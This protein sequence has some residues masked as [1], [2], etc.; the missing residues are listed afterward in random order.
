MDSISTFLTDYSHFISLVNGLAFFVLGLSVA[1]ESE[2]LSSPKLAGPLRM[3]SGYGFMAAL[4]NWLRMFMLTQSQPAPSSNALFLQVA[5]LLSLLLAGTFL[6]GF[7]TQ[8]IA[9]THRRYRWVR[10]GLP[11]VCVLYAVAVASISVAPDALRGEWVSA[12]DVYARYLLLLPGLALATLGLWSQHRD[13]LMMG[14]PR[15]AGASLGASLSFGVK[16]IA[17][18]VVAFPVHG[19]SQSLPPAAVLAISASRTLASIA[20]AFFVVR[21]LR[22]LEIERNRQLNVAL[23]QRV[24]AQQEA[25]AAQRQVHSEVERWARQ[26]E[27]LVDGVASAMSKATSLEEILDVS[28]GQVL[29]LTGFDAGEILLAQEGESELQLI[30]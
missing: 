9:G 7:A 28:L 25:L 22:A 30:T 11:V 23:E 4:A 24:Q 12:A 19:F 3:L 27:D 13:S 20:I 15:I 5:R 14:L 6:L 17:S 18:G 29:Q 10:W 1:L 8:L 21:I 2:G 26:L 16:A